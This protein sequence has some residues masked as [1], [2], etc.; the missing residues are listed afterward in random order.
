MRD[1]KSEKIGLNIEDFGDDLKLNASVRHY[2]GL[3]RDYLSK[4][5]L[6]GAIHTKNRLRRIS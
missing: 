3:C 1:F 6:E 2:Y 4:R 5:G